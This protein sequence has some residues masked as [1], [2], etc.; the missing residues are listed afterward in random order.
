M[1]LLPLFISGWKQLSAYKCGAICV[2]Q[3]NLL[4]TQNK[5]E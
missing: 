5:I 3:K 4:G 2:P 1:A